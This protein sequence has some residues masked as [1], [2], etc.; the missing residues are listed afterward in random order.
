MVIQRWQSL[1]L[2]V[3][4]AMMALFT[5][6]SLGQVQTEA[7]SFN[8]TSMGFSYEGEPT[9]GAPGGWLV[10]TWYFFILCLT[11][12]AVG[13]IDIFLYGNL[14]LQKK[15]CVVSVLLTVASAATGGFLGY[16]AIEG[17]S[18]S[19]SWVALC[20]FVAIVA[21]LMALTCMQRDHNRLRAVDRLR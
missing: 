9:D 8:F 2:L 21:D 10:R 12:L 20:P 18:V 14:V 3:G 7:Y 5:F 11:A 19:W 4:V 17:H 13:F 1:L 16:T 15:I 6:V